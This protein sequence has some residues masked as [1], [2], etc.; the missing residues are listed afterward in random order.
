MAYAT[1]D[2]TRAQSGLGNRISAFVE[3]LRENAARRR[4]YKQT[5]SEL[6]SLSDRELGDLGLSRSMIRRVAWQAAYEA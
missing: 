6:Q 2:T 1:Q 3:G 5:M 4:L